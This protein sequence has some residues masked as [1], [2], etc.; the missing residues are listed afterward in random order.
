[1]TKRIALKPNLVSAS[2]ASEGATTHPEVV[3]GI[4]EYLQENGFENI[5]IMESSWVGELTSESIK[6][7]GYDK[8]CEKYG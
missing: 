6:A 5:C 1:K 3:C 8:V 2:P 4:I 7:C